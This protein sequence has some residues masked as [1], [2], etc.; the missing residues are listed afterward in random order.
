M[1]SPS[2]VDLH[3]WTASIQTRQLYFIFFEHLTEASIKEKTTGKHIFGFAHN[4]SSAALS[5]DQDDFIQSS[6][7]AGPD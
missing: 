5:A 1:R 6:P 3:P 2:E 4:F 7:S